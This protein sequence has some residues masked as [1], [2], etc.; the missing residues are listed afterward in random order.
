M[1][2]SV[3]LALLLLMGNALLITGVSETAFVPLAHADECGYKSDGQYHC[4][5][6]CGYR[7]DGQYHCG[8]NCGYKSDGN[9]HCVGEDDKDAPSP[10]LPSNPSEQQCGYKSDGNY[11]CGT[12]CGYKSDGQYHCGDSCGYKSDGS[13]HCSGD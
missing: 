12:N 2:R 1:L 7:S 11:H 6:N 9:Y 5:S 4:G 13:Y 8:D 10:R 3:V